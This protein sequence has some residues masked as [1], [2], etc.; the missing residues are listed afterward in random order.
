MV[1]YQIPVTRTTSRRLYF[2]F[3]WGGLLV[4]ALKNGWAGGEG[5][6]GMTVFNKGRVPIGHIELPERCANVCFGGYRR[7]RLFMMASRAL[8]AL[9][10]NAS[11]APG[12]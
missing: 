3:F 2:E 1:S 9:W 5:L 6:D 12:G 10:V 7:S 4:R 8:Y 11:G